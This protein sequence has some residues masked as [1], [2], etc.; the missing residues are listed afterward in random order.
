MNEITYTDTVTTI[1][2]FVIFLMVVTVLG[3]V[4]ALVARQAEAAWLAVRMLWVERR[5]R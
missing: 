3:L 2:F 4:C 1:S 5:R